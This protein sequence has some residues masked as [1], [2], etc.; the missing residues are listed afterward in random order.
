MKGCEA[1]VEPRIGNQRR[2]SIHGAE[3]RGVGCCGSQGLGVFRLLAQLAYTAA[4]QGLFKRGCGQFGGTT[5]A[6]HGCLL[7]CSAAVCR[8]GSGR[9]QSFHEVLVE[10]A[11]PSPQPGM[12]PEQEWP[13][14]HPGRGV[15]LINGT[16]QELEGAAL[17][18]PRQGSLVAAEPFEVE[19]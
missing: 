10:M 8:H 9:L 17:G 15:C 12:G 2:E 3:Q 14:Q 13:P 18:C 16:P 6:S 19:S 7:G 4:L 11:F 1:P 5:P